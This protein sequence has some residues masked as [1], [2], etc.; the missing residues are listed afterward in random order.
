MAEL[1]LS[2]QQQQQLASLVGALGTDDAL[3]SRFQA[4]VRAVLGEYGL[5]ELLP[6]DVHFEATLS[7]PEVSGFALNEEPGG[8]SG[9]GS[10]I[11]SHIDFPHSDINLIGGFRLMALPA[12]GRIA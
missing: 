8:G 10:H 12:P 2:D 3:R 7:E 1:H 9:S 4:D 11:D 6:A 5:A